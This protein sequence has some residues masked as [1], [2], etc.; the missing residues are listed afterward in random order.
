MTNVTVSLTKVSKKTREHKSAQIVEVREYYLLNAH[1]T[2]PKVPISDQL[3]ENA[4]KWRYCWLFE[5]GNMRNAHLK[6][7]RK[8]WRG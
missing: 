2:V 3:Q 4:E 1:D 6:T 5:V 8:Q 7:V